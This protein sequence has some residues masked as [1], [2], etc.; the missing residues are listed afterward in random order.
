MNAHF[1]LN[2]KRTVTMDI[3]TVSLDP[4][5]PKGALEAMTGRIVCIGMLFDD[6]TRLNPVVICDADERK[7]LERFWASIT[8]TDL[9]VGHNILAFDLMFIRQRSWI[10][11][12]KP[13]V[14]LNLRKYYT[15]QVVDLMEMWTNWSTRFKGASLDNIATVLGVGEKTGHGSEVAALWAAG[16]TAALMRYCM[17][18]VW[19][20]YQVYCKMTYREPL[21]VPLPAELQRNPYD[22]MLQAAAAPASEPA[23][24]LV[25]AQ[26]KSAVPAANGNGAHQRIPSERVLTVAQLTSE[27]RRTSYRKGR[28]AKQI[29]YLEM[30]GALVLGGS[31][32]PLKDDL[33][34]LGGRVSK[35]GDEW[36][37]QVPAGRMSD[38]A[39]L[40]AQRSIQLVAA[41]E[42]QEARA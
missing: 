13:P 18:D 41:G 36:I 19:L 33:S 37:W 42:L 20:S 8:D 38:L 3:E 30:G 9:L 34:R 25:Y 12:V 16:D 5:D 39:S 11:G 10:L 26:Q 23:R 4:A 2:P 14:V 32:Y 28:R 1:S 31:T 40:C 7:I 15:E 24:E 27:P 22:Q 35:A 29:S 6:G 17:S 21:G